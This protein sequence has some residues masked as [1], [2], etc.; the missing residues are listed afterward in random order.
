MMAVLQVFAP[1]PLLGPRRGG[2]SGPLGMRLRYRL[3][4]GDES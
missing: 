3:R 1:Q 2:A 4:R